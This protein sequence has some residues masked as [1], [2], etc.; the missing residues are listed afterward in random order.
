MRSLLLLLLI[1]P[2]SLRAAE[3]VLPVATAR[4]KSRSFTTTVALDNRADAAVRC[5]FTYRP[6]NEPHRSL[7]TSELLPARGNRLMEDFLGEVGAIG[8]VRVRCN[9]DVLV[10]ARLQD[11]PAG[12]TAFNEGRVF[13]AAV[14][15]QPILEQ[16]RRTI[17]AKTDLVLIEVLGERATASV[18]VKDSTGT[19]IG[20]QQYELP[21]TRISP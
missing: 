3:H 15:D 21:P 7:A 16:T 13:R 14:I 4:Y 20:G 2:S 8:S 5:D 1:L 12:T 11:A 18:E 6:V 19:V 9:G 17:P 10:L